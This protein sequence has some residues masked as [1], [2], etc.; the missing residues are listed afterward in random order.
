MP[1]AKR[2]LLESNKPERTV[3]PRV[4]AAYHEG[5]HC[6]AAIRMCQTIKSCAID[7]A[8]SGQTRTLEPHTPAGDRGALQRFAVVALA[9]GLAVQRLTGRPDDHAAQDMA[10]VR[11]RIAYLPA[12]EQMIFMRE[13]RAAAVRWVDKH[14]PL[15]VDL[16]RRLHRAGTMD[17]LDVLDVLNLA[18]S[19]AAA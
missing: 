6:L 8:G 9:G 19:R 15:L 18:P 12:D 11:Q 17:H 10:N 7:E 2:V 5:A 14:W 13:A 16:A 4:A 1:P 3:A